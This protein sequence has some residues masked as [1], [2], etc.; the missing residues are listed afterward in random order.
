MLPALITSALLA[1]APLRISVPVVDHPF[2]SRHGLQPSM[3]QSLGLAR[4]WLETGNWALDLAAERLGWHP[5]L[6]WLVEGPVLAAWWFVTSLFP[7]GTGWLHEEW[8]RSV[9]TMHGISSRNGINDWKPLG[10][11]VSVYGITDAQLVGLKLGSPRDFT[12]LS[13]AGFEAQAAWNVGLRRDWFF[14]DRSAARDVPG[15]VLSLANQFLYLTGCA[16]NAVRPA[17]DAANAVELDERSRDFAGPDC[18]AWAYDLERAGEPYEARGPHPSGAGVDRYRGADQLGH[19]GRLHLRWAQ[20]L[21]LVPLLTPQLFGV[22]RLPLPFGWG[23]WMFGFAYFPTSFG[24]SGDLELLFSTRRADFAVIYHQYV[25][26]HGGFP[27]LELQLSRFPLAEGFELSA[28]VMG[29]QQPRAGLFLEANG[30]FGGL[31]RARVGFR[32]GGPLEL[33][34]E[35]EAKSDGWVAGVLYQVPALQLRAGLGLVL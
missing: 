3:Q 35:A 14:D 30:T 28:A 19:K 18:T 7:L 17:I 5:A 29:W 34:W 16:S 32:P 15:Y 27:G 2:T 24:H 8:H 12:R 21:S 20:W 31:A 11:T 10:A 22:K 4:A 13:A 23:N 33:W 9:L 26:G 1:A 6:R 25:N